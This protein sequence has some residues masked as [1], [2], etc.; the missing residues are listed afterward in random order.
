[1]NVQRLKFVLPAI[2]IAALLA[3]PAYAW[4]TRTRAEAYQS[5]AEAIAPEQGGY[6]AYGS[7]IDPAYPM[8][9]EH[10]V[11]HDPDPNVRLEMRKDAW[12]ADN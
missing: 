8:Q 6:A 5:R 7:A 10:W 9:S 12:V 2:G 4:G 11:Q 3:S 1:M